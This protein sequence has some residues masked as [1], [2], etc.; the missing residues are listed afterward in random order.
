[1]DTNQLTKSITGYD[2]YTKY[3][4]LH[5]ISGYQEE[6]VYGADDVTML[7]SAGLQIEEKI[8]ETDWELFEFITK[9]N[10]KLRYAFA[11][12]GIHRHREIDL[13]VLG[14]IQNIL[15]YYPW[16]INHMSYTGLK[17]LKELGDLEPQYQEQ[18]DIAMQ[19]VK[20]ENLNRS[21]TPTV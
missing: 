9:T 2:D 4:E 17:K 18:V 20:R 8:V 5:I 1:M 13:L 6:T 21:C 11:R 10:G 12:L 16:L 15:E 3:M 7:K 14:D 19:K